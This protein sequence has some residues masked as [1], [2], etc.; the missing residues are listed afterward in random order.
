[1]KGSYTIHVDIDSPVVLADFYNIPL[2]YDR[3]ML[4]TFYEKTFD[5]MLKTFDRHGIKATFFCVA[6][7]V[8]G[9]LKIQQVLKSAIQ[10]GHFIA[11]HTYSHPFG[12][13]ELPE[14]KIIAEIHN[15]TRILERDL[16]VKIFGFRTPGYA[17][18]TK[19]INIL[20]QNGITY[21][22]SAGWPIFHAIFK[23][24]RFLGS[25]RMKV[26]YGETNSYFRK[27]I[28]TPA[29]NNWKKTARTP[30]KIKEYP[31]PSS[32]YILPCYSNLH[33]SFGLP[34]VKF[35]LN[36]TR[37]NKLM[38]YLMHA[39]E[40]TSVEDDF[41]PPGISVHPHMTMRIDRKL[42]KINRILEHINAGREKYSIEQ[43]L[44]GQ[45]VYNK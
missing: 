36:N 29:L 10:R 28:Y 25:K 35:L 5:R 37:R 43:Q 4:E 22:S 12:L 27:Y 18:N 15:A 13:S 3:E 1:M 39:I 34:F 45:L 32:F 30:R 19:V 17:I 9:S 21:D 26:G 24:L 44:S 42:N 16:Q 31:L 38:I 20:E 23:V 6:S 7:E 41:I 8:E 2:T 33:L 14:E 40:F 11:N